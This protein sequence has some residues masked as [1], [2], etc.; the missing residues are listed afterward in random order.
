[1]PNHAHCRVYY[2]LM[3]KTLQLPLILSKTQTYSLSSNLLCAC[4]R[5]CMVSFEC[6]ESDCHQ[7]SQP[8]CTT[9]LV[10]VSIIKHP[11]PIYTNES[12]FNGSTYSPTSTRTSTKLVCAPPNQVFNQPR[13]VQ[14]SWRTTP[15]VQTRCL[16]LPLCGSSASLV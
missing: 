10:F 12:A 13:R 5:A 7:A 9:Y 3:T 16:N 1:M 4:V 6:R 2:K 14:P 11:V 15:L 8:M